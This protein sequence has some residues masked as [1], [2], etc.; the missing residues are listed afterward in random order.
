MDFF[1]HHSSLITQFPLLIIHHLKYPIRLAPS[2]T[3]H[4]SIYFTLFVG[5]IPVTRC[6]FFYLFIYFFSIPKLT[7]SSKKKKKNPETR[8]QWKKKGKKEKEKETQIRS[9]N[10]V[11]EEE[12]KKRKETQIRS[13]NLVK[14]RRRRRKKKK[15]WSKVATKVWQ[16]IPPCSVIYGNAIELWVMEIE[17]S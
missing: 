3:C 5:P 17:N 12:E 14:R 10:P 16:W 11:K 15:R 6:R 9:P 4:H 2:L 8:T 7:K 13:P 1:F